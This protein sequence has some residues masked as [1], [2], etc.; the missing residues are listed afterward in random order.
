LSFFNKD[1]WKDWILAGDL[2]FVEENY[3]KDYTNAHIIYSKS[4]LGLM[5]NNFMTEKSAKNVI[6]K[7]KKIFDDLN[8]E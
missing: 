2:N 1:K 5:R 8:L 3:T 4:G 7:L 6:T